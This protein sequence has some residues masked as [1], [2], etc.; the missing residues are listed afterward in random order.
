MRARRLALR[1]ETLTELPA[2]ELT[3]VV[4]GAI[5]SPVAACLEPV[6]SMVINC[7]SNLRPCVSN[8]CTR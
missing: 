6:T 5:T 7:D 1:R 4:G 2:G 3:L 8:T